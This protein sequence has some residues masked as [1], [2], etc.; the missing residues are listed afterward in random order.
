[1]VKN[2]TLYDR[3]NIS[4]ISTEE[5][6][7]KAFTKLSKI[8]HP[9]KHDESTKENATEIFKNI[10]EAKEIL[11]DSKKR[12]LYD[13]IGMDIFNNNEPEPEIQI[14]N[15]QYKNIIVKIN[16]TLE[17]LYNEHTIDYTYKYKCSCTACSSRTPNF[18][19]SCTACIDKICQSCSGKGVTINIIKFGNMIQQMTVQ[20]NYCSGKGLIV[21]NHCNICSGKTFI[22]KEKTIKIPLKS[23]LSHGSKISLFGKGHQYKNIKTDLIIILNE[24]PHNIFQRYNND[25][26]INVNLKL[27]QALFGFEKIITHLDNRKLCISCKTNINFNTIKKI[28]NEGMKSKGDLYI[29]FFIELSNVKTL[30]NDNKNQLKTLLQYLD[31]NEVKNE[32]SIDTSIHKINLIDIKENHVSQINKILE[33]IKLQYDFSSK[34]NQMSENDSDSEQEK[35]YYKPQCIQ[36]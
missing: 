28:P 7:K 4:P 16:V 9:D 12:L 8:W 30:N 33:Q 36:S 23:E 15:T 10:N 22:Y 18:V 21:D 13:E 2:T 19:G 20:C 27:Y 5:E 24:L 14:K 31:H 3:L 29:K 17:Q 11:L 26:F 1:M 25:L 35:Q 34:N 32:K 6:I